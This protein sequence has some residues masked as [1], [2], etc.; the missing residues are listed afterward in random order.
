MTP[1]VRP[2]AAATTDAD[3]RSQ[4]LHT[5]SSEPAAG[6]RTGHSC[7]SDYTRDRVTVTVT[8]VF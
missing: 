2:T 4:E 3:I 7:L 8:V 5:R 6:V 1:S